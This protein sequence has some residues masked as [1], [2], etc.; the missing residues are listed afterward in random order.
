M[1]GGGL[2]VNDTFQHHDQ[3]EKHSLQK[4]EQMITI[5][6]IIKKT[7]P[8]EVLVKS[9]N[10]LQCVIANKFCEFQKDYHSD[11]WYQF[12]TIGTLDNTDEKF[13]KWID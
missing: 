11:K 4:L 8:T 7:N 12:K 2:T 10:Y 3:Q 13:I 1:N 5:E 9:V 6:Q